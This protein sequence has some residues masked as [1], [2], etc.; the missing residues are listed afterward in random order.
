MSRILNNGYNIQYPNELAY[1]GMPVIVKISDANNYAGVGVT[2]KVGN[3]YFTETRTLFGGAATF[4]I[5][6]YLQM[7]FI[8]K[9]LGVEYGGKQVAKNNLSQRVEVAVQLTTEDGSTENALSFY[10]RALYGYIAYGQTNGGVRYRK[11]FA[12][13]PQ[14]FDFYFTPNTDISLR[15]DGGEA[16]DVNYT[17]DI[18]EVEQR[19]VEL[20]R[21][22]S[23]P[24]NANTA[25]LYAIHT[26]YLN[27]DVVIVEGESEY[28]L[29]IDRCK[30]GVF[31]RWLDHFGQWCYYLFRTTG[32]NFTTKEV[33]TWQNGELRN[34][35][36][37]I[38][39]VVKSSDFLQQQLSQQ[40]TLSLG[41]KLVDADTFDFLL[42]L[43]SSP[44]VEMLINAEEYQDD[45]T[46]TPIWERVNIVAGSYAKTSAHLQDF[47]V[48]IA[49]TAQK[50]QML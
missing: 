24:E 28:R 9:E 31:L 30:S 38:D 40:H 32:Q 2:V 14:T 45:N 50:T 16:Q 20:S 37:P 29:T 44:R 11:L 8:G 1:A 41:A 7:A 23:V 43:T 6:R 25:V 13:Y 48:S 18:L 49:R 22:W 46:T 35:A 4:D 39:Y 36:E 5:S 47:V 42:S 26:T 33:N 12:N 15:F 10:I 17:N 19:S 34:S 21:W 3:N 27:G